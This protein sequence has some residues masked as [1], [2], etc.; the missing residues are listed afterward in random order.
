MGLNAASTAA[1]ET[2]V[3]RTAK[4]VLLDADQLTS[5][6]WARQTVRL[7]LDL[8]EHTIALERPSMMW[9]LERVEAELWLQGIRPDI[10]LYQKAMSPPCSSRSE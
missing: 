7:D 8:K 3:H 1:F 5:P 2:A 10:T 9:G 6:A 4:Q